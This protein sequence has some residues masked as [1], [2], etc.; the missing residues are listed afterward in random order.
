MVTTTS[1]HVMKAGDLNPVLTCTLT[2]SDGTPINLTGISQLRFFMR[3]PRAT[4]NKVTGNGV[5]VDALTGKVRYDWQGTETDTPGEY[6][7]EWEI[8]LPGGIKMTVSIL[9]DLG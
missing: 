1:S 9:G 3:L 4:V 7:A 5:V 2:Y 8:G 6:I